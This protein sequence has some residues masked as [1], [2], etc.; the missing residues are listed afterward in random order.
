MS[1]RGQIS[2]LGRVGLNRSSLI[3]LWVPEP[4][5]NFIQFRV[6]GMRFIV[7]ESMEG[8]SK[9]QFFMRS[10]VGLK[11]GQRYFRIECIP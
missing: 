8:T 3:S 9:H 1:Q 4:T 6:S 10:A 7:P 11:K 2:K 5:A